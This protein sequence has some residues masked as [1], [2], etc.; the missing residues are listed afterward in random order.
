[1][2][3]EELQNKY[4]GALNMLE[5]VNRAFADLLNTCERE[6]KGFNGSEKQKEYSELYM[7][8]RET[9]CI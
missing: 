8:A 1:M 2:S 5:S 6:V 3:I 4:A 9:Y 7:D